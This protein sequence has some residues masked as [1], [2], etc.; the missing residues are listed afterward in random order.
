MSQEDSEPETSSEEEETPQLGLKGGLNF[1]KVKK[2][3]VDEEYLKQL[4]GRNLLLELQ[5]EVLLPDKTT[6]TVTGFAIAD[7]VANLKKILNT[8]HGLEED[9]HTLFIHDGDKKIKLVDPMS[10]NDYPQSEK[11]AQAKTPL[12]I[13][14]EKH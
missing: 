5:I 1:G 3:D 6:S 12:K 7:S 10:M 9:K 8:K 14:C 13:V 2:E 4:T 11:H